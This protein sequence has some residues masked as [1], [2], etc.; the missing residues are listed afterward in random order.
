MSN[1]AIGEVKFVLLHH[2]GCTR[3]NF[4]YRI[5]P[6]GEVLHLFPTSTRGQHPKSLG[7][8]LTGEFDTETP[9]DKQI[10]ALKS[11]L[12]D[13]KLRFPSIAVGAH[14]QVRGDSKTSCPGTK[15][16]M[17]DLSQWTIK[18][19]IEIRDERI[20]TDIESQYGP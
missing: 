16:P 5:E 7:I 9:S 17:K 15:F 2:D 1:Q 8:V 19:L 20:R 6:N 4:H 11:L 10:S 14:R 12:V 13:L 18:E 3:A